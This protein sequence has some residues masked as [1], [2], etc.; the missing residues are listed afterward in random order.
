MS[1]RRIWWRIPTTNAEA[2]RRA[3]GRARYNRER[4]EEA[5]RR[6][7]RAWALAT[8]GLTKAQIAEELGCSLA[9]VYRYL[10]PEPEPNLTHFSHAYLPKDWEKTLKLIKRLEKRK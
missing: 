3:G 7:E 1:K 8:R 4:K 9:S 10:E 2:Y 6:K 5:Q